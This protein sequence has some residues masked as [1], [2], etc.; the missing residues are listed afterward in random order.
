MP[1]QDALRIDG[2]LETVEAARRSPTRRASSIVDDRG[3]RVRVTGVALQRTGTRNEALVAV[4]VDDLT[5]VLRASTETGR[6][7]RRL[8]D[9]LHA[10]GAF[11]WEI[12][13]DRSTVIAISR[14]AEH[15]AG[16]RDVDI[17]GSNAWLERIPR[18]ERDALAGALAALDTGA[19]THLVHGL[20]GPD[21]TV[22]QFHTSVDPTGR[23]TVCG[24]SVR[25]DAAD[26]DTAS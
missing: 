15:V 6:E 11:T 26:P 8:A 20:H 4:V 25:L 5:E 16:W 1:V 7:D 9:V 17:L 10:V 23:R 12:D 18:S 2:V 3:R 24:V 13:R 19:R 22:V 14:V 21:G